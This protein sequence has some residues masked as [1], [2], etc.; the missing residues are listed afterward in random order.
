MNADD[1]SGRKSSIK[2]PKM[3]ILTEAI[4]SVLLCKD[5]TTGQTEK[6]ILF[7]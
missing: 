7:E 4:R 6:S 3:T 1:I 5:L 2:L